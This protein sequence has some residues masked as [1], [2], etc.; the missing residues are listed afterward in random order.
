MRRYDLDNLRVIAFGLLIFYHVGMVFVPW[1]NHIKDVNIHEGLVLPMLF[2]NQWR[3]SILFVISGMGTYFALSKRTGLQLAKER[4]KRLLIPLLFGMAFIVPPQVYYEWLDKGLFDGNYID[5]YL[6]K[7]F[8]KP[9]PEGGAISWHHLWFVLYLLIFSLVLIPFFLHIVRNPEA[10]IIKKLRYLINKSFGLFAFII[11]LF[12][13]ECY[14]AP[15]YPSTHALFGDW[16]N[17]I[18]YGTLFMSG[19]LFISLKDVFWDSVQMNKHLYLISGL[20]AFP[21]LILLSSENCNFQGKTYA[22]SLVKVFNCWSWILCIF[23]YGATYLNRSSRFLSYANESVYPLYILHQTVIVIL[24]YYIK[25][26]GWDFGLKFSLMVIGT[27]GFSIIIYEFGI[28]R[29][30][31]IR[32]LFGLKN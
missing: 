14:L 26:T 3:L 28:R 23:G 16:F 30:R 7:S 22:F 6:D 5:F 29:L 1:H 19:F 4:I 9:Y 32:P 27:F 2:L 25:H 8:W 18:N 17:L 21:V 12:L 20:I 24:C 15:A 10:F 13:F 31:W 11:P